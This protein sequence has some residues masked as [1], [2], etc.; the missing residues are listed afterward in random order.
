MLKEHYGFDFMEFCTICA[1]EKE[2][3]TE[4]NRLTGHQMGMPRSGLDKAIDEACGRDPDVE[5]FPDFIKMCLLLW[6]SHDKVIE[7]EGMSGNE[8]RKQ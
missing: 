7:A 5:A 2:L 4:F 6:E 1:G 8:Q 3:V